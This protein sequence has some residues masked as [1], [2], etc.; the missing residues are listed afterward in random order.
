MHVPLV[1]NTRDQPLRRCMSGICRRVGCKDGK[2]IST[3][4]SAKV[5]F[6]ESSDDRVCDDANHPIT[7]HM[8][9]GVVELLQAVD[10]DKEQRNGGPITL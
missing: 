7:G 8:A 9:V 6:A 5:R 1:G 2:L 10:V 4:P 3:P